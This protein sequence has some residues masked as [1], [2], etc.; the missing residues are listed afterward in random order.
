MRAWMEGMRQTQGEGSKEND[1]EKCKHAKGEK[2]G[3]I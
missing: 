3:K 2:K 1:E